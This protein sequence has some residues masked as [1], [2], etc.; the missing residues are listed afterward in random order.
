MLSFPENHIRTYWR[1]RG[2][3]ISPSRWPFQLRRWLA[4]PLHVF[5]DSRLG[6]LE[7]E[8]QKLTVDPRCAPQRVLMAHPLNGF[9]QVAINPRSPRPPPRFPP[10]ISPEART[11]PAQDRIG[12]NYLGRTKKAGPEPNQPNHKRPIT[13]A[14][15]KTRPRPPQCDSQLMT[16]EQ[17]LGFKPAA[18]L[19]QIDDK[20]SQ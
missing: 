6:D 11:M 16:E 3:H 10:P 2:R 1:W 9:T 15:P 13:T 14:Q 8:H 17:I 7:P 4:A 5:R 20:H 12:L 18:R 19:E